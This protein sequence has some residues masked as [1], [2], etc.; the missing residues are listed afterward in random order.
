MMRAA[1]RVGS[2]GPEVIPEPSKTP[3]KRKSHESRRDSRAKSRRT[4]NGEALRYKP[5]PHRPSFLIHC[6]E[7]DIDLTC[8]KQ[9]RAPISNRQFFA[10]LKLPDTL[11]LRS[12]SLRTTGGW[13]VKLFAVKNVLA[14]VW[15]DFLEDV[16]EDSGFHLHCE[17]HGS[18]TGAALLRRIIGVGQPGF[19]K[20]VPDTPSANVRQ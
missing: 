9:I 1:T 3:R 2:N 13:R 7:L 10:F 12:F 8:T 14:D 20:K 4:S 5:A 16:I 6:P 15:P 17:V 19:Q 11:P 18:L